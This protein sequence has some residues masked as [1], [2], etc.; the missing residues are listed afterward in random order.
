M[1]RRSAGLAAG[2]VLA[3]VAFLAGSVVD[4]FGAPVLR[5]AVVEVRFLSPVVCEVAMTSAVDGAATVEHRIEVAPN[6]QVELVNLRGGSME[7]PPAAVG[8]T[9]ALVVRP[10]GGDYTLDYRVQM[11]PDRA[12]RCPL[13][14]AAVPADGRSRNVRIEVAIPEGAT[15]AG[16]MPAFSWAG[17]LGTAT[18]GHLPSFVLVPF[19]TPGTPR[20]WDVS[21]VMDT[22][23]VATLVLAS[24]AWMWRA[25]SGHSR[26]AAARAGAHG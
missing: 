4:A 13:W 23:A 19:A 6:T 5:S 22:V 18:V 10:A 8:R 20:P 15:P 24:L 25:R 26:A 21:R 12:H 11:P 3:V 14:L 2:L 9:R 17:A 16:T 1:H 7:R